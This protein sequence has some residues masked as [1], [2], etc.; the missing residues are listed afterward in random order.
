M[1][2]SVEQEIK[3]S[4]ESSIGTL[5]EKLERLIF[6]LKRWASTIKKGKE[7]L[8]RKLTKE[9][10]M[11]MEKKRDDEMMAK[12]IDTKGHLNMAIDKDE[13][14][15]EQRVRANWLQLG[16]K[17][18]AFFHKYT[19][20]CRRINTISTL[21]L[22]EGREITDDS[23]IKEAATLFFQKLF[24]SNEVGDLSHLLTGIENNISSDLNTSL[25]SSYTAE[26][27]QSALKGMGPIKV[28]KLDGFLALFFQRYWHII[29]KDVETFCLEILNNDQNFN[30]L[31]LT[32]IVLIPKT[33]NP[34][35]LVNYRPICL[36]TV[37]YKI[38]AKTI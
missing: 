15:W 20:V 38:V 25:L 30:S 1:E 4:W 23:N 3:V 21:E 35:N 10:E 37:I 6:S 12:I 36:C 14:Y 32:D 7:G 22:D 33:P 5:I 29:G 34:T 28:P 13:M 11:L 24:T 31:N 9:L 18:L 16:D 26:E 19:S 2:E 27:V 17:I 8:K